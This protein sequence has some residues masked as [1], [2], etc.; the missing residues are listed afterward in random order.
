MD[1]LQ[2]SEFFVRIY[3]QSHEFIP[4]LFPTPFFSTFQSPGL[5]PG[6]KQPAFTWFHERI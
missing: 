6:A 1:K 3:L 2:K 4:G 5:S